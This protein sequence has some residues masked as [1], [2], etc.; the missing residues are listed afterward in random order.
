MTMITVIPETPLFADAAAAL[1]RH[2]HLGLSQTPGDAHSASLL[3]L[4]GPRLRL[5]RPGS[6]E[7]PVSIDFTDK[8]S[9]HRRKHGGGKSQP[10][11]KA[12]GLGKGHVPTVIDATAGLGG[13][14]FVLACLGCQVTMIERS[15]VLAALLADGL[16]RA[17]E[18]PAIGTLV[19]ERLRLVHGNST[20]LLAADP[21]LTADVIYL[22]PMYPHRQ[23]NSLVKKEMRLLRLLLGDD[24]DSAALLAAALSRAKRRVVVKRPRLAPAIDGVS[25]SFAYSGK[26]SRFDVY[27]VT[28]QA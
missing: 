27:L 4:V 25:P 11:A 18:D 14:S 20:E 21:A 6:K 12:V 24:T 10:V 28:P 8:E 13:D 3:L 19:R 1:A 2:L 15:P 26:S 23:K 9:T 16:A 7:L 5:A 17:A 22:D